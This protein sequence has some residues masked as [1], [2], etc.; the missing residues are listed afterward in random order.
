MNE[1]LSHPDRE[2]LGTPRDWI[3][4]G[5]QIRYT[6]VR[7]PQADAPPLIFIH[8]FGASLAHWRH[9]LSAI[10]QHHP[11]YALDLLG[12]GASEKAP[13]AYS[14]ELW[15]EQVYDFWRTVVRRPAVWV[16]HSI[17][18]LVSVATV[19]QHPEAARGFVAVTLPDPALRRALLPPFARPIVNSIERLFSSPLLLKPVFYWIR[20]PKRLRP[21]AGVAYSDP[22]AVDDDLI[23]MFSTPAYDRG[24]SGS[25]CRL[26][27]ASTEVAFCPDIAA[28]LQRIQVPGLLMWG[29]RDRMVPPNLARP[30]QFAQV[31][32]QLQL[33]EVPGAG[34]CLHDERPELVNTAILDWVRSR[35]ASP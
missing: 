27:R 5:W 8:G 21:W 20:H 1:T 13:V 15:A 29:D 18:S 35:L 30:Q 31:Q 12:F 3:W 7:S 28:T 34:H 11:V 9:N 19:A 16:G 6:T 10:S 32:P 17:G 22:Q 24:A 23:G 26:F 25:F 33:L 2:S 14:I 4:R